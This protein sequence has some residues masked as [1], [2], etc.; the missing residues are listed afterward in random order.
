LPKFC[1]VNPVHSTF[2]LLNPNSIGFDTVSHTTTVPSFKSLRLWVFVLSCEH[3][4]HPDTHPP[5][6]TFRHTHITTKLS[7]YNGHMT[8]CVLTAILPG[9]PALAGCPLILLPVFRNCA[10][11]WAG[12]NFQC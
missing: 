11:F 7:E 8:H 2:D 9:E 12:L 6:Y 4:T 3:C 10:S 5:T 1:N